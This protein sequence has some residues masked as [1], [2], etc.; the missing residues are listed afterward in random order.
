MTDRPLAGRTPG[1][2]Q[3]G[4]PEEQEWEY[5]YIALAAETVCDGYTS[6][7]PHTEAFQRKYKPVTLVMAWHADELA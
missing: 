7:P 2:V 1:Y 4:A 6:A 3:P 5:V